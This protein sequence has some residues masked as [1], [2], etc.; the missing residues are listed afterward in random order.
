MIRPYRESEENV[1]RYGHRAG[2]QEGAALPLFGAGQHHHDARPAEAAAAQR[3]D[4]TGLRARVLD[5]IADA[6]TDGLTSKE[7]RGLYST[8]FGHPDPW[9]V[10]PRF[11]ELSRAGAIVDS[12][13]RRDGATVWCLAPRPA[14]GPGH[15][16]GPTGCTTLPAGGPRDSDDRRTL[17]AA[18]AN[19]H[20]AWKPEVPFDAGDMS[21]C[22]GCPAD[23][24][25]VH[26]AD[27]DGKAHPVERRGYVGVVTGKGP[28]TRVGYTLDGMH[29][30]VRAPRPD[31]PRQSRVVIFESHFAHCPG[32]RR[33]GGR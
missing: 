22:R 32:A 29:L 25:W 6:G 20:A 8:L 12:G 7:A 11:S 30:R 1:A 21:R 27:A 18:L 28:F 33:F 14:A 10:P 17:E 2:G 16:C 19:E 31:D 23:V 26:R 9:S 15:A 3:V 4:A 13:Q 5:W 24:G